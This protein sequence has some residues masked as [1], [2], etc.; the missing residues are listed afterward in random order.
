MDIGN[1][2]SSSSNN[3]DN[4]NGNSNTSTDL[5]FDFGFPP[6]NLDE[7]S[8]SFAVHEIMPVHENFYDFKAMLIQSTKLAMITQSN[9][10]QL[11]SAVGGLHTK[12]NNL[13]CEV[14][15]LKTGAQQA[16][17]RLSDQ[18]RAQ[19][20]EQR[21]N[22]RAIQ[23]H[24]ELRMCL[25][26]MEKFGC[27][28]YN[29]YVTYFPVELNGKLC[30]SVCLPL[31]TIALKKYFSSVV[32]KY[33]FNPQI[34]MRW[35]QRLETV[36]VDLKDV[37]S[38]LIPLF[39]FR[40]Y[41]TS[42]QN[43]ESFVVFDAAYFLRAVGQM[44]T[45]PP[46]L[47]TPERAYERHKYV[48]GV[49]NMY[50][51]ASKFDASLVNKMAWREEMQREVLESPHVS[52]FLSMIDPANGETV[53]HF[54]GLTRLDLDEFPVKSHAELLA[55]PV[56]M[57]DEEEGE[58]D[59]K[60]LIEVK[61]THDLKKKKKSKSPSPERDQEEEKKVHKRVHKE[62]EVKKRSHKKVKISCKDSDEIIS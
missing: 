62:K 15:D 22:I 53:T 39:A 2:S 40:G 21:D 29:G 47:S 26:F 20:D 8:A 44:K 52:Q 11:T 57:N 10:T 58:D 37:E 12:I 17:K 9:V 38:T 46:T 25:E 1:N 32:T 27:N 13:S 50:S 56:T 6:L 30:V 4:N 5:N 3:D 7:T 45:F 36:A 31:L 41:A 49:K 60:P 34:L 24:H 33:R 59:D 23:D 42:R 55:S 51:K 48:D 19:I 43:Q 16:E 28:T 54:C 61:K 18:I 14:E 35:F